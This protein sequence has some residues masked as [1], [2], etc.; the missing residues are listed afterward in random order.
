MLV[1][2]VRT[3]QIDAAGC[4]GELDDERI[5]RLLH[6]HRR[7]QNLCGHSVENEIE[8]P[9]DLAVRQRLHAER[10][11]LHEIGLFARCTE[12][13]CT[14]TAQDNRQIFPDAPEPRDETFCAVYRAGVFANRNA[15]RALC[16]WNRVTDSKLFAAVV[17]FGLNLTPQGR[18]G[19]QPLKHAAAHRFV[20]KKTRKI[21]I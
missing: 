4:G 9:A 18:R 1:Q 2:S 13:L 11:H 12:Y 5:A 10:A 16:R 3:L 6:E 21:V 19:G 7:S 14:H 17:V 15:D 20:H 8:P